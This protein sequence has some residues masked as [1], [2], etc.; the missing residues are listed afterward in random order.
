MITESI[1]QILALTGLC[2]SFS[3]II[4]KFYQ[5]VGLFKQIQAHL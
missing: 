1:G 5:K 4:L 2:L 3:Q